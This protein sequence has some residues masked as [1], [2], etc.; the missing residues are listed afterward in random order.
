MSPNF[1]RHIKEIRRIYDIGILSVLEPRISGN[2]RVR[3]IKKIGFDGSFYVDAVGF[4][5][6][7]WMLWDDDIWSIKIKSS[8]TY[9]I[10]AEVVLKESKK[11]FELTMV[12]RSPQQA[13]RIHLWRELVNDARGVRGAWLIMGDF[14]AYLLSS[15]KCSS[16]RHDW[17]S[18]KLFAD[19]LN[20]CDLMH[21]GCKGPKFTWKKGQ[22][23]ER[24]DRACSNLQCQLSFPNDYVLNGLM[25]KSDHRP[26]IVHLGKDS[27][28]VCGPR[29]FRFQAAWLS[30]DSFA[31][32]V[33]EAWYG[34]ADWL[35][36]SR[37][38]CEKVSVW[39]KEIFGDIFRRKQ[40]IIRRLMG[41]DRTLD[42]HIR[43]DLE[44]LRSK[45]WDELNGILEQEE[46]FWFQKS[47][48]N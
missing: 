37:N 40:S 26:V 15:E 5:G 46:M 21:M 25:F 19:S 8:C 24:L 4:S 33:E 47:R 48:C 43:P 9:L 6:G 13:S 18:M 32:V 10:H 3:I 20:H 2:S 35:E 45:L 36:G 39:N 42:C 16:N 11:A 23:R 22:L 44:I 27:L 17:N 29:P 1:L 7:I 41:I 34:N 28:N 30:H 31:N 12:Y 14:N 38:F